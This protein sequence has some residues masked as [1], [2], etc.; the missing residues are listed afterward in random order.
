MRDDEIVHFYAPGTFS[1]V[2]LVPEDGYIPWRGVYVVL[3]DGKNLPT[4]DQVSVW[5]ETVSFDLATKAAQMA[6]EASAVT[7]RT[8]F[9]TESDPLFFKEQ[10]GEVPPGTWL[11][12][13]LEIK[14]R[15]L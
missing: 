6:S 5:S 8:M 15:T 2:S 11:A 7:R 14:G 12:K 4:D 1:R 10:A 13:R 3:A 9:E